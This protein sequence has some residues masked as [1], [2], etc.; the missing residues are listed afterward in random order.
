MQ[1]KVD[2]RKRLYNL[3][4]EA[5]NRLDPLVAWTSCSSVT[6]TLRQHLQLYAD[7][8]V[9]FTSALHNM[10]IGLSDGSEPHWDSFLPTKHDYQTYSDWKAEVERD[11]DSENEDQLSPCR[12]AVW[13]E[14]EN[15][16]RDWRDIWT[17]RTA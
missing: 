12:L 14:M 16:C 13:Q 10:A 5:S 15:V 7:V 2:F 17:L 1:R 9:W 3:L 4:L 6:C 11:W 8:R